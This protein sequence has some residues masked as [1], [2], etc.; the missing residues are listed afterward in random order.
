MVS[1][2]HKCYLEVHSSILGIKK[3]HKSEEEGGNRR[4]GF[5]L[6]QA[7]SDQMTLITYLELNV[8]ITKQFMYI[9]CTST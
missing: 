8:H 7:T 4:P 2:V 5:L 9:L 3:L 1:N 6:L